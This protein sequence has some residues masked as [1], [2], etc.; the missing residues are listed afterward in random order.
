[1]VSSGGLPHPGEPGGA[2]PRLVLDLAPDPAAAPAARRALRSLLERTGRQEWADAAEL[3]CTELVTNVVLHAHTAL[4]LTVESLAEELR[5]AVSDASPDL[6]RLRTGAEGATTGRGLL[7]VA[8]L[9]SEHGVRIEPTGKT[10]WFTLRDAPAADEPTAE[11]LLSLW[12]DD[13][14]TGTHQQPHPD[15]GSGAVPALD[16]G[17]GRAAGPPGTPETLSGTSVVDRPGRTRLLKL[18]A[19]LWLAAEEHHRTLLREL[20]LYQAGSD[21]PATGAVPPR[22]PGADRSRETVRTRTDLVA[23]D[24]AHTLL[25]AAVASAV[26]RARA[27]GTARR[28]LPD[29]HP[30]DLPSVPSTIDLGLDVPPEAVGQFAALQDALDLGERLATDGGLLARPGLP[31]IVAVRDWACEQVLAQAAGSPAGAWPGTDQERFVARDHPGDVFDAAGW[32]VDAVRTATEPVVAADD[33][34]RIVALS[35]AMALLVLWD[36]DELVGR[37][38]VTLIPPELREAH[39]AGFSRHL[40]TGR[41]RLLGIPL[42]LP[43]LRADGSVLRCTVTIEQAAARGNRHLYLAHFTPLPAHL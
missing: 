31:E 11:D 1:M 37:R 15:P 38:I 3:A 36:A 35:P 21:S 29:E 26:D 10:V 28:P 39:V 13:L 5:V 30:A 33:S 23:A 20:V 25:A 43:V 34:N 32:D 41:A 40:S 4:T 8:Q 42:V 14:D 2:G 17:V 22:T 6:P 19:S 18:P 7:L 16:H 12:D 9:V 24:G 27:T